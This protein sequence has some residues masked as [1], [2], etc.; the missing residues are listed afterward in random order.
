MIFISFSLLDVLFVVRNQHVWVGLDLT[1]PHE[2]M[3]LG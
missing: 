2:M 3:L 1:P